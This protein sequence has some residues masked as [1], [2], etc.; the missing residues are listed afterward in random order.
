MNAERV[1][2]PPHPITEIADNAMR[3]ALP[4]LLSALGLL[5]S[6]AFSACGT[7]GDDQTEGRPGT[8]Q[9]GGGATENPGG[10]NDEQ[11]DMNLSILVTVSDS[12][13]VA[14]LEDN[15]ASRAFAGMLPLKLRMSE[16]NGNEKYADLPAALPGTAE[17]P[18]TIRAGDLMVWSDDCLV[19][20]YATFQSS[21]SYIRL[22]RIADPSGLAAAVG[23]GD[24]EVLFSAME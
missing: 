9:P 24:V 22:G 1:K 21:Y 5:F 12:Q 17:R 3:Y 4:C 13:F 18:G 8:W 23:A 20:F 2:P 10:S 16:L 19:L 15:A 6:A 14:E 7:Q 11:T